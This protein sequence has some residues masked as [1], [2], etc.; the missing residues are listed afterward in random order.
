MIAAIRELK[1]NI[2]PSTGAVA[3]GPKAETWS[4]GP[5]PDGSWTVEL[6]AEDLVGMGVE[7]SESAVWAGSYTWTFQ[8]GAAVLLAHAQI[9]Y[10]CQATYEVVEDFV[11]ITYSDSDSFPDLCNGVVEDVQW[12]LDDDGLHFQLIAVKKVPFLE[13]KATYEAKPWQKMK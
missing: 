4:D 6:S 2:Q 10:E 9:D 3:C 8:G 12:R 5:L 11:R 1:A 13:D 7:R